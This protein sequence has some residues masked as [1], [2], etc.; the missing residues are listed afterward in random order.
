MGS[1]ETPLYSTDVLQVELQRLAADRAMLVATIKVY[2]MHPLHPILPLASFQ[3][4]N[5][6]A[7]GWL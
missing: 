3:P 2:L 4:D 6:Q 7:C 1:Q 5:A